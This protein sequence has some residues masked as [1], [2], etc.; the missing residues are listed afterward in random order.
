MTVDWSYG[1]WAIS[2]VR[3]SVVMVEYIV[4]KHWILALPISQLWVFV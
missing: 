1:K 3:D 2:I 4:E